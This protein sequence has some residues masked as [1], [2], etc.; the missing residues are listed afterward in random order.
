MG[1]DVEIEMKNI[2]SSNGTL[3]NGSQTETNSSSVVLIDETN[4]V[5]CSSLSQPDDEQKCMQCDTVDK[6]DN[7]NSTPSVSNLF[8]D[9][10]STLTASDLGDV[11]ESFSVMSPN[12]NCSPVKALNKCADQSQTVLESTSLSNTSLQSDSTKDSCEDDNWMIILNAIKSVVDQK[13]V[14]IFIKHVYN[15][16]N[17]NIS[18]SNTY[19][20]H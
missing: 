6:I 20:V 17:I 18:N 9:Y 15:K 2:N 11:T 3:P 1:T 14:S 5:D 13:V 8:D 7:S 19:I 16:R 12:V 4:N 10:S